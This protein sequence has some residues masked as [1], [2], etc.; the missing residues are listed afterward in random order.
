MRNENPL[1]GYDLEEL[2]LELFSQDLVKKIRK[3]NRPKL[4][5]DPRGPGRGWETWE[6]ATLLRGRRARAK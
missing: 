4:I 1:V 6:D 3:R 2:S 5:R